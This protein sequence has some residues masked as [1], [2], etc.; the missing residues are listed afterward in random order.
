M[1]HS[2]KWGDSGDNTANRFVTG[3][4]SQRNEPANLREVHV[5]S[6]NF[7]AEG[8]LIGFDIFT[9]NFYLHT[10]ISGRFI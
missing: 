7:A 10:P 8:P 5:A 1:D 2:R 9:A 3:R 6:P 4:R